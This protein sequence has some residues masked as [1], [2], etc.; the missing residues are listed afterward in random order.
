MLTLRFV[1]KNLFF[2]NPFT[3]HWVQFLWKSHVKSPVLFLYGGEK[4]DSLAK[5]TLI[6][7]AH[8]RTHT[9]E[10]EQK[11][12]LVICAKV[13]VYLKMYYNT[14]LITINNCLTAICFTDIYIYIYC[15]QIYAYIHMHINQGRRSI[16]YSS[17][18]PTVVPCRAVTL[19]VAVSSLKS[20]DKL[21]WNSCLV[22]LKQSFDCCCHSAA[23][24]TGCIFSFLPTVELSSE[25]SCIRHCLV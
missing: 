20:P 7:S 25:L 6:K 4:L 21:H 9:H 22:W 23:L 1:G 5:T 16:R 2:L 15:T 24:F 13:L 11:I 10:R 8:T 3:L 18:G 19:D 17:L 14:F 12:V